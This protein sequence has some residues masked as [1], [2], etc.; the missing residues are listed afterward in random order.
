[1]L[2][3]M[4]TSDFPGLMDVTDTGD[5]EFNTNVQQMTKTVTATLQG[6]TIVQLVSV[7]SMSSTG[8]FNPGSRMLT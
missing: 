4:D 7:L 3:V 8:T 2:S 1:M 5:T 6:M